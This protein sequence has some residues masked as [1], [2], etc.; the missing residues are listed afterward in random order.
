M[1]KKRHYSSKRHITAHDREM[2]REN[3]MG[4]HG[5]EMKHEKMAEKH[6]KGQHSIYPA[7]GYDASDSG[8]KEGAGDRSSHKGQMYNDENHKDRGPERAA[9][10]R[11]RALGSDRDFYAGMDARRRREMEDAGMLYEDQNAVAN[12]PQEVMMKPYEHV[13]PYMP[14]GLND[15]IR[16]VDAQMGY[17]DD[18]RRAHWYPKKV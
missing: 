8:S 5:A 7:K 9:E 1:A 16:G 2:D 11:F 15:D 4:H 6:S 17:D 13:G 18:Q 3:L 12:L 14:E 10:N